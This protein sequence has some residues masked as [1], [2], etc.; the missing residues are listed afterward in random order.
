MKPK[1][2]AAAVDQHRW[3]E[4]LGRWIGNALIVAKC[5]VGMSGA[6]E[7]PQVL[8][9]TPKTPA[10]SSAERRGTSLSPVARKLLMKE[11]VDEWAQAA[12][13]QEQG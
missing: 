9:I 12:E 1:V 8:T 11:A 10:A 3:T 2:E 4:L 6:A 7:W 13:P 5:S